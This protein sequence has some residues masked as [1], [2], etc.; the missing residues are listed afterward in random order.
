MFAHKLA[1]NQKG[2][3]I[4]E[5]LI[6]MAVVGSVLGITYVTMNR[7][8]LTTRDAQERTEASKAAQGQ[9]EA[10]KALS[11]TGTAFPGTTSFCINGTT[12]VDLGGTAPTSNLDND[13]FDTVNY[14]VT[15]V[16]GT[17][18]NGC[19]SSFYHLAIKRDATDTKLWRFYV[20]WDQVDGKGRNQVIMVYRR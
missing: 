13:N 2:D 10:F 20:R 16:S 1:R 5:V 12:T 9:I 17:G 7:N 11:D 4:V 15:P 14:P 19:V 18:Q 8:L 3:T 6:A